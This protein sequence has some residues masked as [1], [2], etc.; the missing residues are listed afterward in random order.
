MNCRSVYMRFVCQAKRISRRPNVLCR[1]V[2]YLT[3][4]AKWKMDLVLECLEIIWT[5]ATFTFH[6]N[7]SCASIMRFQFGST[8]A[9][10]FQCGMSECVNK[11]KSNVWLGGTKRNVTWLLYD[12]RMAIIEGVENRRIEIANHTLSFRRAEATNGFKLWNSIKSTTNEWDTGT[13]KC[14]ATCSATVITCGKHV[15]R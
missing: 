2:N 5:T 1:K 8:L 3:N 4:H 15:L 12:Q 13:I 10:G 6:S 7:C 11:K 14:R 9:T